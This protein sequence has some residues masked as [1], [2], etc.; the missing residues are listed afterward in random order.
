MAGKPWHRDARYQRWAP[1]ITRA[2]RSNPRAVCCICGKIAAAHPLGANGKPQVWHACHT[3]DGSQNWQPWLHV[4]RV[5][6]HG[7]YLAAGMSRC[8]IGAGNDARNPSSGWI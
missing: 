5:P 6:P 1:V 7:D 3:R 4:E 2:A 8:N